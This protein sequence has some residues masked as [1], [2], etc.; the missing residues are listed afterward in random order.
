MKCPKCTGNQLVK[1][2]KTKTG[3]IL[4]ARVCRIHIKTHTVSETTVGKWNSNINRTEAISDMLIES[5]Y[6]MKNGA[7]IGS[8]GDMI[9]R[10]IVKQV[11]SRE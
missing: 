8:D 2:G 10:K 4:S 11:M 6:A 1:N 7:V 9:S 3:E 5:S